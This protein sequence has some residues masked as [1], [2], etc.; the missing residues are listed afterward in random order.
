MDVRHWMPRTLR[1]EPDKVIAELKQA[2]KRGASKPTLPIRTVR[3]R[4]FRSM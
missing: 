1:R 2:L 3:T 4:P